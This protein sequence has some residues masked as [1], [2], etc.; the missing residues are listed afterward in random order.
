MNAEANYFETN[1]KTWNEKT[2]IH[3]RSVFYDNE[4]FLKG[5]SSLKEIEMSLLGD[6]SGKAF[7]TSNVISGK[8]AFH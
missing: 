4:N 8:T 3:I 6:I 2:G 7:Y 5:K 1:K